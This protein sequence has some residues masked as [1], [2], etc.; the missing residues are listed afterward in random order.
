MFKPR[1]PTLFHAA[2]VSNEVKTRAP[3]HVILPEMTGGHSKKS[4]VKEMVTM[5]FI[6]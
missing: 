4:K 1:P 6:D 3:V 2:T 5:S